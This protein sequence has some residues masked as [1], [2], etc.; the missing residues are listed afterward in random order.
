MMYTMP[1]NIL[2]ICV[3]FA[4]ATQR[5]LK[6]KCIMQRQNRLSAPGWRRCGSTVC[7]PYDCACADEFTGAVRC[8]QTKELQDTVIPKRPLGK[9]YRAGQ[10][11]LPPPCNIADTIRVCYEINAKKSHRENLCGIYH[12]ISASV[13][14]DL[15][16]RERTDP[17]GASGERNAW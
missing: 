11:D 7:S 13:L 16:P 3:N 17:A 1:K 15:T 8:H 12:A 14:R 9:I 5:I 6:Q 4:L 2:S 10:G